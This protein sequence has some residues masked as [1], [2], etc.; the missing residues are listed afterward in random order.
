[1]TEPKK[2]GRP[3]LAGSGVSREAVR[4]QQKRALRKARKFLRERGYKAEDFFNIFNKTENPN[5]C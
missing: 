3:K 4:Q 5:K 1:V 2:L